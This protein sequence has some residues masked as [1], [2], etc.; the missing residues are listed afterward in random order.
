VRF[1][2]HAEKGAHIAA[3]ALRRLRFAN[4][5]IAFVRRLVELHMRPVAYEDSW[6]DAAVRR[7]IRDAGDVFEDLLLVAEADLRASDYPDAGK[8]ERLRER[9]ERLGR[10]EVRQLRSPLDG[11]ELMRLAG[12]EGGP[13]LRRVKEALVDAVIEGELVPEADAARAWLRA[14][15]ELLQASD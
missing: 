14:H 11:D 7:L 15:A 13:W 12:R 5:E 6:N 2:G 1:L 4:D 10:D 3:E 9:A 8:C